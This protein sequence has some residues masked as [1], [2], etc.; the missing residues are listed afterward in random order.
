MARGLFLRSPAALAE[1]VTAPHTQQ[2]AARSG[3]SLRSL[4]GGGPHLIILFI[5]ILPLMI[6]LE[7]AKKS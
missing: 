7:T 1:S 4:R 3:T 2:S 6:I 5:L